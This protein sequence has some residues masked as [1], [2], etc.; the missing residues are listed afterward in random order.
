MS[1]TFRVFTA[2]LASF[3]FLTLPV[4]PQQGQDQNP[5]PAPTEQKLT[6]EQKQKLKKTLKELD[7]PYKTDR[8]S[9]RLNSSHRSLSRMPSSA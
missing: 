2:N 6:K 8:K 7:T 4:Y 1:K 9:T 3:V 5:A